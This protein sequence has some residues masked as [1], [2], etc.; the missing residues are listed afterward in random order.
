M[1][2]CARSGRKFELTGFCVAICTFL[3]EDYFGL[4]LS[5]TICLSP[6]DLT[7]IV[8]VAGYSGRLNRAVL[9]ASEQGSER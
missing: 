1:D 5:E 7:D 8:R 4:L 2:T 9:N 3:V 6:D